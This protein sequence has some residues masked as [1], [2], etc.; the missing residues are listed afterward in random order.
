MKNT[1]EIIKKL[2]SEATPVKPVKPTAR[3][4]IWCVFAIM[5]VGVAW[6]FIGI[7]H[8]FAAKIASG[9][10]IVEISLALFAGVLSA[11]AASWLSIPGCIRQNWLIWLP[12]IPITMLVFLIGYQV[13]ESPSHL[14]EAGKSIHCATDVLMVAAVPAVALFVMLKFAAS[15]RNMITSIMA[16]TAV[17]A[18]GYL[19]SRFICPNDDISHVIVW[20][21]LPA[22]IIAV[23]GAVV[24]KKI[25]KW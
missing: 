25:L 23:V 6:A 3:C 11:L 16:V 13:F 22:V 21:Y 18:F 4:F 7:R 5:C 1:K 12:F 14:L 15:T 17:A 2:A 9:M 20:H 10:F 24:G 8:D 19:G